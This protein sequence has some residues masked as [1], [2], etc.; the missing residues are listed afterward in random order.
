[1]QVCVQIDVGET[2]SADLCP[3]GCP[4]SG[5]CKSLLLHLRIG[6]DGTQDPFPCQI[7]ATPKRDR[8]QIDRALSCHW[9]CYDD[10]AM[11]LAE[12]DKRG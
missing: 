8:R 1:M 6:L 7:P 2:L 5:M 4:R 11:L 10:L 3:S 9:Y 12:L